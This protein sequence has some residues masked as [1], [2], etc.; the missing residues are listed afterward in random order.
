MGIIVLSFLVTAILVFSAL[1]LLF[2]K[3]R[4]GKNPARDS[5]Y[6]LTAIIATP[7]VYIGLLFTWFFFSSSYE[8]KEFNK[9]NWL[10][11][12]DTRYVYVD[13]LIDNEKLIG[14]TKC[15]SKLVILQT[16]F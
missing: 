2:R 10:E 7:I 8:T 16:S 13:D 12:Q 4:S 14:L 11:D 3:I 9:E 5:R 1:F 15:I 6:W